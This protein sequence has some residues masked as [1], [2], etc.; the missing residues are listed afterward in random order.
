MKV[1]HGILKQW[2]ETPVTD[3]T[4]LGVLQ[5][6]FLQPWNARLFAVWVAD[7]LATSAYYKQLCR[8]LGHTVS[9]SLHLTA[10]INSTECVP[11]LQYFTTKPDAL[12]GFG[13]NVTM[14]Y[15][16]VNVFCLASSVARY[17]PECGAGRSRW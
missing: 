9:L 12:V 7:N 13:H 3:L 10:G 14:N 17:S 1:L 16:N 8:T 4:A 11:A 5:K 2:K 6:N 15:C